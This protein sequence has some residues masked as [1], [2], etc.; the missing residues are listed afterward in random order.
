MVGK[1]SEAKPVLNLALDRIA[2]IDYDFSIDYMNIEFNGDEYYK[3]TIGVTVLN[4]EQCK[5]VVL[6]IDRSNAPYVITK[7]FHHSQEIL[8]KRLRTAVKW[9]NGAIDDD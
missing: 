3:N 6:E 7:P 9:G 2:K 8:E 1:I 4:D 5:E